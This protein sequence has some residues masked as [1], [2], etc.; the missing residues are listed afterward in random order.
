MQQKRRIQKKTNGQVSTQIFEGNF[1][2]QGEKSSGTAIAT[3]TYK[4]ADSDAVWKIADKPICYVAD[5]SGRCDRVDPSV[6]FECV[7]ATDDETKAADKSKFSKLKATWY[8]Q[9]DCKE[10][11][12]ANKDKTKPDVS[13]AGEYFYLP[14]EVIISNSGSQGKFCWG[15]TQSGN[16]DFNVANKDNYYSYSTTQKL[17]TC[18][19]VK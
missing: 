12:T 18:P 4:S 3:Y 2:A 7:A 19:P 10:T 15:T 16:P 6:K 8:V 13:D 14:K 17:P 9:E 5:C 11:K 1:C